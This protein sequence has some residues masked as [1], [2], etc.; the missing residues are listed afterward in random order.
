VN[1]LFRKDKSIETMSND[2]EFLFR[3]GR[4]LGATEMAGHILMGSETESNQRLGVI[5][6]ERLQW[7][8][9]NGGGVS[10]DTGWQAEQASGLRNKVYDREEETEIIGPSAPRDPAA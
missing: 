4:L 2:P 9:T 6:L 3:I 1:G 5:L 8:P 10:Y 7:F